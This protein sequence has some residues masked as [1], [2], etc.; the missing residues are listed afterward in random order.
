MT[1]EVFHRSCVGG[2]IELDRG[3]EGKGGEIKG[4]GEG[5][6]GRNGGKGVEKEKTVEG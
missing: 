2:E 4:G 3:V 6:Q 1:D 5:A